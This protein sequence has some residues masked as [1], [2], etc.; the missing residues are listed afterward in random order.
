VRRR[1]ATLVAALAAV[2]ASV[3]LAATYPSP[4]LSLDSSFS[5][6]SGIARADFGTAE[7]P[8]TSIPLA[9]AVDGDRL[10]TVGQAGS[11]SDVGIMAHHLDGTLDSSFSDD[12]RLVI[13]VGAGSTPDKA[14]DVAVLA[15]H[16]I[17]ILVATG[18]G[19]A[20]DTAIIGLMPDGSVDPDFGAADGTP[21]GIVSFGAPAHMPNVPAALAVGGDGRLAVAGSVAGATSDSFVA[22]REANGAPV[23][24]FGPDPAGIVQFDHSGDATPDQASDVVF[25]PGGVLVF[26]QFGASGATSAYLRAFTIDGAVDPSFSDDGDLVPAVGD[27]PTVSGALLSYAGRYWFTGGTYTG[28]D[29][30]AYLARVEADGSGLQ[31]RQFDMR[32]QLIDPAQAVASIGDALAVVPGTPDTL[33]VTG[34]VSSSSG[35]EWGAAAFNNLDLDVAS[36]G[37][38]DIAIGAPGSFGIAGVA[39]GPGRSVF[40]TGGYTETITTPSSSTTTTRFAEARLLIDA[41]KKCN[42]ALTVPSPLELVLKPGVPGAVD[43]HVSNG[44]TLACGGTITVP[45]P[46]GLVRNGVAGPIATGTL[47]PGETFSAPGV[48]LAYLGPLRREDN[49]AFTL[50]AAGDSDTTDNADALHVRFSYCDLRVTAQG[51]RAFMPDEGSRRF[52]FLVGNGGT[53]ACRGVRVGVGGQAAPAGRNAYYNLD[54]G[55]DASDAPAARLRRAA[56]PGDHVRITFHAGSA[57]DPDADATNDAVTLT[58]TVL[59]V[60]DTDA[61]RPRGAART[62]RGVA[63]GGRGPASRKLRRVTRVSVAVRRLGA[64]CRWLTSAAKPRFRRV[65][66]GAKGRCTRPVWLQA[67]GTRKWSLKTAGLPA[68]HYE[69][70]SRATIGAGFREASFTTGDHNR[71]AFDV[72]P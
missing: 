16:R 52:S 26:G 47:A 68:G 38:G 14:V 36:L 62:L 71:V 3:A 64:G 57:L 30:N 41:E 5:P 34:A 66:A 39:A 65:K 10:Y 20:Q 63:H 17:R 72:R 25:R 32:G 24:T 42:L 27:A 9:N 28:T 44:G 4:S 21:D 40:I 22:L 6:P 35:T 15:D 55:R 50:T 58:P 54:A 37:F 33:V 19:S 7:A 53:T 12:G 13:A 61:S 70:L 56:K 2:G 46:Y 1:A 43:L 29:Q 31:S 45:A 49:L 8:T 51:S 60:G 67:K 69:L 11:P 59:G 23:P 18:S 48:V